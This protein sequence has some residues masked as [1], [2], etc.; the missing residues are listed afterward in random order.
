MYVEARGNLGGPTPLKHRRVAAASLTFAVEGEVFLGSHT[1]CRRESSQGVKP[2]PAHQHI[3]T[4]G[5]EVEV[6]TPHLT[7]L[8]SCVIV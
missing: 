6:G 1:L 4:G 7:H 5:G 2:V 8:M 3:R